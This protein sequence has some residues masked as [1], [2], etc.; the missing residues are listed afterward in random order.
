[1][2]IALTCF[3]NPSGLSRVAREYYRLF[4]ASGFRT[5]PFWLMDPTPEGIDPELVQ[6]MTSAAGRPIE[7]GSL[8]LYVGSAYAIKAVKSR[9]A[10]LG[11]VVFENHRLLPRQVESFRA[12]DLVLPPT[13]FCYQACVSSGIP[14]EK[15]C[16]FPYVLGPEYNPMVK[17]AKEAGPRFRFLYL[18]TWYERKGY[19]ALLRAWWAEFDRDDPVELWIKTYREE[20]RVASINADISDVAKRAGADRTRE[21]PITIVDE[22]FLDREVAG[23]MRS[24]D[25]YVSPHRS[26]GFGMNVWH[27]M[28]LGIPV[29][30]TDYGGVR[31]FAKGDTARLVRVERMSKPGPREAKLFPHLADIY[32][33]NP[34]V[35]DLRGQ[36]RSAVQ[37][38]AA[39]RQ[40]ANAAL[41]NVHEKYC[42]AAVLQMFEDAL[43]G[44]VPGAWEALNSTRMLEN[45]AG[46][47]SP[48]FESVD[49]PIKMLEI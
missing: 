35:E 47:A 14:K 9:R 41:R 43:R 29:I 4:D 15:T 30:C 18:N 21:A 25:C 16:L 22:V 32:W 45:L 12:M 36:M 40:L 48:R 33:A 2:D 10:L 24:C 23:F 20:G 11:S 27:A 37:D 42:P 17:P 49:S 34:D 5:I 39:S 1:M 7:P 44:K 31:D 8:Q 28:A 38:P 19:D 13:T 3:L 46:Q 26:E 6:K